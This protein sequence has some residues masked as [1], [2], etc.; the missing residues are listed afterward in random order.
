MVK[1]QFRI[2]ASSYMDHVRM[3]LYYGVNGIILGQ[4]SRPD[5]ASYLINKCAREIRILEHGCGYEADLPENAFLALEYSSLARKTSFE[6]LDAIVA[7]GKSKLH[8]LRE[9]L[10]F[11]ADGLAVK[12]L[13]KDVAGK[14]FS[15]RLS[16]F[17]SLLLYSDDG[18]VRVEFDAETVEKSFL[19]RALDGSLRE[20]EERML[21]GITLLRRETRKKYAVLL[22]KG[23]L[24]VEDVAKAVLKSSVHAKDEQVWLAAADW[25]RA[26]GYDKRAGEIV[27][28]KTVC[29]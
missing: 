12:D 15:L 26:N 16:E 7:S 8:V 14:G 19:K 5:M 25:L 29:S 6:E 9:E 28:R 4:V 3:H 11:P 21:R 10:G 2:N 27:A 17:P 20:A 18:S 24:S 22:S 13:F 1:V 23:K